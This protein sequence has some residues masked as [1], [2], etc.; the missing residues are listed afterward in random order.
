MLVVRLRPATLMW[1]RLGHSKGLLAVYSRYRIKSAFDP[2][3]KPAGFP[4]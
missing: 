4:V 2:T 3:A 1:D